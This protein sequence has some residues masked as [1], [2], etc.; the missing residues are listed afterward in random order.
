[1]KNLGI[2][3]IL[4][5][6]AQGHRIFSETITKEGETIQTVPP[7]LDS[8]VHDSII[9]EGMPGGVTVRRGISQIG[10]DAVILTSYPIQSGNQSEGKGRTLIM[11]RL[12]D[13][14]RIDDIDQMLQL[15]GSLVPYTLKS[16]DGILTAQESEA[17]KGGAIIIQQSDENNTDGYAIITGIE[18]SHRSSS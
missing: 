10:K 13:A 7:E 6:D 5:Y 9:P 4:M 16:G 2:D 11:A 18:N 3:Y 8:I 12:L 17:A 14:G 1:M 15:D